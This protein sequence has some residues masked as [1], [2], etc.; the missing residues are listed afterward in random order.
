[1]KRQVTPLT[2]TM[3][4]NLLAGIRRLLPLLLLKSS[5]QLLLPL[6]LP[7]AG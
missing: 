2:A 4:T 1:M 6:P 7:H 3:M 5:L